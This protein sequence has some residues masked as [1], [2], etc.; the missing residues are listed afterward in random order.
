M[1]KALTILIT[2]SALLIATTP[3]KAD[4]IIIIDPPPVPPPHWEP[5]L[6]IQSHHVTVSIE[7]QIATTKIDQVFRNDGPGTAEGTYIFPLPPNATVQDFVI[8][9]DGEAIQGE[10]LE[11]D[12]AREIYESYV[13][14]HRDPAL[15]EYVGRDTVKAHIFPIPQ[16]ENRRIQIEY[17]EILRSED[18]MLHYRYP[19]DTERFSAQPLEQVSIYVEIQSQQD[20]RA[21]YSPSHQDEILIKHNHPHEATVSYEAHH[22]LP[23]RDFE[24]YIGTSAE[25]IEANMITYKNKSED[26]FFLLILSPPLPTTPQRIVPRDVLLVLDTSGSMDGEKLKQ[27]KQALLYI[28]EHLNSEDRFNIVA[29]SSDARLYAPSLQPSAEAKQAITWVNGLQALGGTNI[30]LALSKALQQVQEN[31]PAIIIFLTDGLPTEGIVEEQTL[32]GLLAAEAPSSARIFP[33]GVGYDVN[34]LLL[35]ELAQAHKGRSAYVEP[36]ERIDE[37]VSTFYAKVQSPVL[38]Q[39]NLD[40]GQVNTYDMYPQSP[41]DLY[42]G[43]QLIIAGRYTGSGPQ[44]LTLS[45]Y[46]ENETETYTYETYFS[47]EGGKDFIPRLW[48]SRKIGYLLTQIRLHG[49]NEEWIHAIV[50]LSLRYGIITPYTSFLIEEPE[51]TLSTYGRDRATE[52]FEKSLEFAPSAS[53]EEAVEDAIMRDGLGGAAA[54]PPASEAAPSNINGESDITPYIRYAGDKAFLC[55]QHICTDTS[56]IPDE[57]QLNEIM[58][59]TQAYWESIQAHPEWTSYFA[60]NQETIFVAPDGQAYHFYLGD[61][62][63][64]TSAPQPTST[65]PIP[66]EPSPTTEN[67]ETSKDTP[68]PRPKLCNSAVGLAILSILIVY[69]KYKV[70]L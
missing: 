70:H 44:E 14:Q 58:F 40:F 5:W 13:R 18:Q 35:D 57:M 56:Y 33:F 27:A 45:G 48:A 26:G 19:L 67:P 3:L 6:T 60:L 12:K 61:K 54:P 10:I 17:T 66:P 42:A 21:L 23:N 24:L 46:I 29:F 41:S 11:A 51:E 43:A 39:I 8:W 52:E 69:R 15:L 16:G 25:G 64:E 62:D 36:H 65:S 9:V 47:E 63:E 1:K 7:D 68:K 20:V 37:H 4:G 53:G 30:Y 50:T 59:M 28:L 22:I 34:T 49:E 32:L 38:T 55:E 31:R 2:L